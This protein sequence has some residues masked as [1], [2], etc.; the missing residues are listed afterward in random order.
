MSWKSNDENE[1]AGSAG[2]RRFLKAA[3]A[4]GAVV[5]A[6]CSGD[7]EETPTDAGT[8]TPETETTT[9][10]EA[11]TAPEMTATGTPTD[12]PPTGTGEFDD[13]APLLSLDADTFVADGTVAVTGTLSNPYLFEVQ[14]VEVSMAAPEGWTVSATGDTTFESIES[15]AET[16]TA[17]EVTVPASA[18]GEHTLTATVSYES[19]TDTAEAE[20][21]YS[22]F[23]VDPDTFE[24]GLG[25]YLP[26]DEET[27]YDRLTGEEVSLE[28]DPETGVEGFVGG[29]VE[30]TEQGQAVVAE[31]VP[32]NGEEATVTCWV[33]FTDY[34]SYARVLYFGDASGPGGRPTNGVEFQFRPPE[35]GTR[36]E[37]QVRGPEGTQEVGQPNQEVPVEFETWYF[38]AIVLDGDDTRFHTFDTGGELEGSPRTGTAA[39]GRTDPENTHLTLLHG[40]SNPLF[41]RIDEVRGYSRALSEEEVESLYQ[42]GLDA[43]G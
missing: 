42:D 8:E 27:P 40:D 41:G 20:V 22:A 4:L 29:A 5:L 7:D 11:T 6:G 1:T 16:E 33:R 18:R 26:L 36:F 13:P 43:S 30:V 15:Q 38:A 28:G 3:G 24:E 19:E 23:V 31:G 9:A 39:R 14:N 32:I 34:L 35:E 37:T 2:R 17:W 25:M 10:P 12:A 21:T